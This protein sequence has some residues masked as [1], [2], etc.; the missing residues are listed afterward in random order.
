MSKRSGP[1]ISGILHDIPERHLRH[2]VKHFRMDRDLRKD[3]EE[4]LRRLDEAR[5]RDPDPDPTDRATSGARATAD[6][7]ALHRVAG[8]IRAYREEVQQA[9]KTTYREM[10]LRHHPDRGGSHEA[11]IAIIEMY[12]RLNA[13]MKRLSK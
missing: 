3:I 4:H 9:L 1:D 6:R 12:D 8:M 13:L 2:A 5:A 7:E 10:T 11:M